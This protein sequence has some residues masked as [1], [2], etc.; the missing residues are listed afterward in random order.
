MQVMRHSPSH[1]TS[2]DDGNHINK[3]A[4]CKATAKRKFHDCRPKSVTRLVCDLL[5]FVVLSSIAALHV[6][7]KR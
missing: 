2:K 1:L 6:P 5:Q 7:L 4:V 3:V